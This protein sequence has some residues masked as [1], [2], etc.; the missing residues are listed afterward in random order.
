MC[1]PP[2]LKNSAVLSDAWY[3]EVE[4]PDDPLAASCPASNPG[5]ACSLIPPAYDQ[6]EPSCIRIAYLQAVYNN[7]VGNMPVRQT[8]DNLSMTLAALDAAHA[9][10]D[11]PAPATTLATAKRCLGIDP[12]AWIVNYTICPVCWKHFTPQQVSLLQEPSCTTRDC[13]GII[14]KVM[15][16]AKGQNK[17]EPCQIISQVSL[18]QNL[19]RILHRKGFRKLFCDSCSSPTKLNITMTT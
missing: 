9:L 13:S 6:N 3:M 10:P 1:G 7:V 16:N 15:T 19:R 14:C 8:N 18:I 5:D 11:I 12:D 2:R 17:R 4:L